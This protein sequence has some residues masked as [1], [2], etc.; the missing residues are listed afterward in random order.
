MERL[1]IRETLNNSLHAKSQRN[2]YEPSQQAGL[3]FDHGGV[4]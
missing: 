3:F 1:P 2:I 4:F